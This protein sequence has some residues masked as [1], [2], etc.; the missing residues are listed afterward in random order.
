LD[1]VFQPASGQ[2]YVYNNLIWCAGE[3]FDRE[4]YNGRQLVNTA[5]VAHWLGI[6][7]V[8]PYWHA[9]RGLY[10]YYQIHWDWA[11]QGPTTFQTGFSYQADG[12]VLSW[13]G[14]MSMA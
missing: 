11:W 6:D 1:T 13:E 9:M 8:A 5:Q 14:M 7:M 12:A 2:S 3:D 4:Y 10:A